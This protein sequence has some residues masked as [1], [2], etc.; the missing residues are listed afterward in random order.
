MAAE[1][2]EMTGNFRRRLVGRVWVC[3]AAYEIPINA[4]DATG[5][6]SAM[7]GSVQGKLGERLAPC[8]LM[9]DA[10]SGK[11]NEEEKFKKARC[12]PESVRASDASG[13]ASFAFLFGDRNRRNQE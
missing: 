2:E 6:C 3:Y 5:P 4:F 7:G 10:V 1:Y 8:R 9:D 11:H 12:G 13:S